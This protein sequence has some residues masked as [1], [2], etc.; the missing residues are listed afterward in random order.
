MEARSSPLLARRDGSL[1]R[2]LD[3]GDLRQLAGALAR[4][5]STSVQAPG[6]TGSA[7]DRPPKG[8]VS[9]RRVKSR[10]SYLSCSFFVHPALQD[11][12]R[13]DHVDHVSPIDAPDILLVE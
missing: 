1:G 5:D 10:R 2:V 4:R 11:H 8:Q 3:A 12:L 7:T 6:R 9:A 13:R